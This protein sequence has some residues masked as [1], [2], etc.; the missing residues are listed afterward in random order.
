MDSTPLDMPLQRLVTKAVWYTLD[1]GHR[2]RCR[3]GPARAAGL[4]ARRRARRHRAAAAVRHLRPVGHRRRLDRP[5]SRHRPPDGVRLQRASRRCRFRGPGPCGAGGLAGRHPGRHRRLRVPVRLPVLHPVAQVRQ[6]QQPARQGRRAA[7]CSTRCWRLSSS[8]RGP[9]EPGGAP[10]SSGPGG[11]SREVDGRPGFAR[12]GPA[13]LARPASPAARPTRALLRSALRRVMSAF[14][15]TGEQR[16]YVRQVRELAVAEL[17]PLAELRR[18]GN[19]RLGRCSRRWAA[20]G[21]W[22][23]C[24]AAPAGRPPRWSC[25]CCA[26]RWPRCA[27]T[28][29]PRWRCRR[30]GSYPFV[31]FGTDEI[32]PGGTPPGWPPAPWWHPSRCR[33]PKPDPMPPRCNCGPSRTATAGGC[34]ARRPGSPTRRRP[35][36]TRCSPAP[37]R[38]P[39]LVASPRSWCPATRR[40]GRRAPGHA[41]AARA[42]PAGLRR[43]PGLARRRAGRGGRQL[44]GRDAHPGRAA[45]QRRRLRGRH[46]A[47][48]PGRGAV[49]HHPAAGFRRPAVIDQQAV[50][51]LLAEMATRV[52]ASRLLVYAAAAALGRQRAGAGD[53]PAVG[54]GQA[55]RHRERPVR[56]G[57]RGPVARRPGGCNGATCWNGS[58]ATSGRR[59]STRAPRRCSAPSSG[60]PWCRARSPR[61]ADARAAVAE[62]ALAE[63]RPETQPEG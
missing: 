63:L 39:G 55:V 57:Y 1:A 45:A 60:G 23:G 61:A 10:R 37:R 38:T 59:G 4:A 52:A 22:A 34:T 7:G 62:A 21:C 35:T 50:S 56:G 46:G 42:G 25:A 36:C 48:R 13:A 8:R 27:P 9:R 41:G 20:S 29:R 26:R 16:A 33:R 44:Q 2:R 40:T 5:A 3:V 6:R 12:L 18:R 31:L 30:L 24:S 43:R 54:D 58:T 17:V 14:A 53:H 51:H 28:P 47:G 49:P 32:G 15:L 19:G 11:I